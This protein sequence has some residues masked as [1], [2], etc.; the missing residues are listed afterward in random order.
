MTDRRFRTRRLWHNV[1]IMLWATPFLLLIGVVLL[2]SAGLFAPLA[3]LGT[4]CALGLL[5]ALARDVGNSPGYA[6]ERGRLVL[7]SR[8]ERMEIAMAGISDASL[9]DRAGAREYVREKAEREG[10]TDRTS[11]RRRSKAFTRFCSVDI[12]MT[13]L[14]LGLGRGM[15]DRLPGAKHDLVLLRTRDGE[16]LLLSPRYPNDLVSAVSRPFGSPE[17]SAQL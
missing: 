8:G 13:S 1:L 9:I 15:V 2:A 5:V 14:T 16:D 17:G 11:L 6:L 4:F 12:G 7:E 10:G 3:L